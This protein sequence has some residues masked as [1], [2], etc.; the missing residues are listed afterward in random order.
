[1][2]RLFHYQGRYRVCDMDGAYESVQR[3]V[4]ALAIGW[5]SDSGVPITWA[6]Y[7]FGELDHQ[8]VHKEDIVLPWLCYDWEDEDITLLLYA[9][10]RD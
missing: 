7:W 6:Y 1:M 2:D 10:D 5:T 4:C 3:A 9:K 8:I